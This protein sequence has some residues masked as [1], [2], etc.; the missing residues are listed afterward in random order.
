MKRFLRRLECL[1]ERPIHPE[2]L[3][4]ALREHDESGKLPRSPRLREIVEFYDE[5]LKF[6]LASVQGPPPAETEAEK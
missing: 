3:F 4:R 2:T 1:E 5:S 6:M